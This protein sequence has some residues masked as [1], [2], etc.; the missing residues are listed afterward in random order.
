MFFLYYQSVL[1]HK[2]L[3]MPNKASHCIALQKSSFYILKYNRK[4]FTVINGKKYSTI[5]NIF[6]NFSKCYLS[7]Y[8]S[9]ENV[10]KGYLYKTNILVYIVIEKH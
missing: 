6:L 7:V 5:Y 8:G 1:S 3:R 4:L 2:Y 9:Q 10:F